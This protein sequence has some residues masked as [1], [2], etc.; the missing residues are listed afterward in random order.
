MIQ[1]ELSRRVSSKVNLS[2][3]VKIEP[4]WKRL[5]HRCKRDPSGISH[6]ESY[7]NGDAH[8]KLRTDMIRRMDEAPKLVNP[9]GW[10]SDGP[11]ETTS[12][13]SALRSPSNPPQSSFHQVAFAGADDSIPSVSEATDS[14][15]DQELRE[16]E[17][18]II[19]TEK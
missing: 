12:P 5:L 7:E 16:A 19:P 9:S 18:R 8:P 13:T 3:H 2:T 6:Q 11:P 10:I 4:W 15:L 1:A 14:V 17:A